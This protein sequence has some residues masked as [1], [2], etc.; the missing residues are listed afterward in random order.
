MENN[1]AQYHEIDISSLV[2]RYAHTRIARPKALNMMMSS[3]DR[4]GQITPVI[5]VPEESFLIL[6]DGYLRVGALKLLQ[7]EAVIAQ[8]CSAGELSALLQLLSRCGRRQWE[9][10]EQAWIIRDIKDRFGCSLAEIARSIGR[11]L[12]W[13]SRRHSLIDAL[14][15]DILQAICR[16]RISTWSATRVLVPLARANPC[17]AERLTQHLCRNPMSSR[18]LSAFLNHYES[19]NKQVRDRMID[20]PSLFAK[21]H[22]STDDTKLAL[23]LDQGPEGHWIKDFG[24]VTGVLR[25][26]LKGVDMVIYP[27]QDEGDRTRLVRVFDDA[28]SVFKGIEEK[29]RKVD[30]R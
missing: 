4:F 11:D 2:L 16:G 15:E 19:S 7:R 6:I 5:V 12:S 17:H 13:V 25:R 3:M 18:D 14:S 30:G 8:I 27:G 28:R 10:V 9:A 20:D 1:Q 22:K 24:T 23:A 26:L 29:I 21:A